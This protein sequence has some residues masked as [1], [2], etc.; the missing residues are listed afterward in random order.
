MW[1]IKN[2]NKKSVIHETGVLK[3][4]YQKNDYFFNLLEDLGSSITVPLSTRRGEKM[5][6]I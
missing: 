1:N 2:A 3:L 6:S 4:S 5:D